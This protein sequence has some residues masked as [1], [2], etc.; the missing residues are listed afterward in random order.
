M[1][2]S[3]ITPVHLSGRRL[4]AMLWFTVMLPGLYIISQEA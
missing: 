1:Q 2:Q 3:L 4:S